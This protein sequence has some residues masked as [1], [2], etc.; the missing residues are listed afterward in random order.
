M[1]IWSPNATEADAVVGGVLE[2]SF[3]SSIVEMPASSALLNNAICSH[4]ISSL[5]GVQRALCERVYSDAVGN[6]KYEIKFFEWSAEAVDGDEPHRGNPSLASFGCKASKAIQVS[7]QCELWDVVAKSVKE[8][9]ACANHGRCNYSSGVCECDNGWYGAV[10]TENIDNDDVAVYEADGPFFTGNLLRLKTRRKP[11]RS[12][13]FLKAMAS[14]NQ[15]IFIVRGDGEVVV[16][17][18]V[19]TARDLQV[20]GTATV[21]GDTMIHKTVSI[22]GDL[23]VD[24]STVLATPFSVSSTFSVGSD[25]SASVADKLLVGGDVVAAKTLNAAAVEAGV[26]KADESVVVADGHVTAR[27]GLTASSTNGVSF[28]LDVVNSKNLLRVGDIMDVLNGKTTIRRGGVRVDGGGLRIEAGGADVTGGVRVDGGLELRSGSFSMCD[29]F[30]VEGGLEA[31]ASTATSHTPAIMAA[32]SDPYFSGSV[33]V[34]KGPPPSADYRLLEGAAGEDV[35]FAVDGEG[36]LRAR[37]GEFSGVLTVHRALTLHG[38]LNFDANVARAAHNLTLDVTTS[39]FIEIEDD[40]I[41]TGLFEATL[42]NPPSESSTNAQLLVVVNSDA[43]DTLRVMS[44]STDGTIVTVPPGGAAVLARVKRRWTATTAGSTGTC[45]KER[46]V[47]L[48]E[49]SAI[50]DLDVGPDTF[51]TGELEV[52]STESSGVVFMGD[53]QH[54]FMTRAKDLSVSSDGTLRVSKLV[55]SGTVDA[56]LDLGGH[57]IR[58]ARLEQSD[59]IS[60]RLVTSA[61]F[62]VDSDESSLTNPPRGFARPALFVEGGEIASASDLYY[63]DRSL[64][65]PRVAFESFVGKRVDFNGAIIQNANLTGGSINGLNSVSVKELKL[66]QKDQLPSGVLAVLSEQGCL[67]PAVTTSPTEE[68]KYLLR[69][70]SDGVLVS[71][72]LAVDIIRS[73]VDWQNHAL[74]NA[75]FEAGSAAGLDFVA[76]DAVVVTTLV[77]SDSDSSSRRVVLAGAGGNLESSERLK[78]TDDG[79]LNVE[80]HASAAHVDSRGDAYVGG[81]LIVAGAVVGSGPYVDSSDARKKTNVR[82]IDANEIFGTLAML[83]AYRYE[84][85]NITN[86]D[87]HIGFLAQDVERSPFGAE[88]VRLDE[89]GDRYVAYARFTPLF[90]VAVTTL[91][92]ENAKLRAD[93]NRLSAELAALETEVAAVVTGRRA[94]A[95]SMASDS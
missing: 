80:G 32:A 66:Q 8:H 44:D 4:L 43:V 93:L 46:L 9:V 78:L 30:H 83:P 29:G 91:A 76:A 90:A 45:A 26:F 59:V 70:S 28:A 12:F 22:R 35:V 72:A 86:D 60:A 27:A 84:L 21:E 68:R 18:G 17:G 69:Y 19:Q 3:Y 41:A 39:S 92:N 79:D 74:R 65:V 49:L 48:E 56:P 61:K 52:A 34:A 95:G 71:R 87:V 73:D 13:A 54:R 89:Q 38:R 64:H 20:K 94:T 33:I 2:F 81:S 37:S 51:R 82:Q 24:G 57:S 15:P 55:V 63:K 7:V 67:V 31:F 40:A 14:W 42:R 25:G 75:H 5:F 23:A 10:C 50:G 47:D 1:R 85:I 58:R 53:K 62:Q 6:G 16:S 88:L 36:A 11:D 77:E